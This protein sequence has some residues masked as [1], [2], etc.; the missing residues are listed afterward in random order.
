MMQIQ[1]P[2][3]SGNVRVGI[4]DLRRFVERIEKQMECVQLAIWNVVYERLLIDLLF[5]SMNSVIVETFEIRL[6]KTSIG[7]VNEKIEGIQ[8][9]VM[10]LEAIRNH[11]HTAY[12]NVKSFTR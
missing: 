8:Y 9:L 2:T 4:E 7:S 1:I 5:L 10:N 11:P 3:G 12:L 6:G